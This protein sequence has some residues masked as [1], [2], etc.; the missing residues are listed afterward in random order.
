MKREFER[1]IEEARRAK[2]AGWFTFVLADGEGQLANVEG[3]PEELAVELHRGSLARHRYGTRQMTRLRG[4]KPLPRA[5]QCVAMESLLK[6]NRGKLNR[7]SLKPFFGHHESGTCVCPTSGVRDIAAGTIYTI[8]TMLF[9]TS[10]RE[11]FLSRGPGCEIK[12]KRL[13]FDEA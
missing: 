8:D 11:A 7:D 4:G 13:G 12:W 6:A 10:T 1:L 9:N 5:K 2:H 3:S